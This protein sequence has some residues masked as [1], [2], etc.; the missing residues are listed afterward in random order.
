MPTVNV[1]NR[2]DDTFIAK[3]LREKES[4]SMFQERRHDDWNE[5][6]ELYRNKVF[7]NRL[8]QRQAVNIPL[9]KETVKTL[10]S[11]IDDPPDVEWKELSGD[12]MKE[13]IFQEVWNT[14]YD[15]HN[16][17]GIDVQDKKNVLLFGRS[18]KKLNYANGSVELKVLDVFDV[19]VDPL[20]DPLDIET[21]RFV[22]HRNIFRSVRDILADER[23]DKKGR[24][25]L[26]QWAMSDEGMVMSQRNKEDWEKKMERIRAMGITSDEFPLFAGGDMLVNLTEHYTNVWNKDEKK[27]ERRVAVYAD[28]SIILMDEKLT[29]IIG[30]EFWPFV[31]WG[32]DVETSDF[33]SDG[34]A[35]LVRTPNKVVNIW[36][37]QLVENRTLRNFQMHWFDATVQNF[38][39]Q[40]Y[41]PGPGRMLPAPGKPSDTIMP[42]EIDGLDETFNAIN[43]I[44]GIIE[45]GTSATAIEKGVSERKQITLGEVQTLVGKAMERTVAMAKFY[46]RSWSELAMKWYGIM[47]ANDKE[48][49]EL[50]KTSS[51]GKI[52]AKKV[53]P[54]DWKSE[55]GYKAFVRSTSEQE[56]EKTKAVQRFQFL[57]QV[58]PENAALRRIGQK[59]MLELAD[60]TSEE[61]REIAE[62]E[63]QRMERLEEQENSLVAQADATNQRNVER[64]ADR[65]GGLAEDGDITQRLS[66]LVAANQQPA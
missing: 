11:K 29:E 1:I 51:Q 40:T 57:M 65:T 19:I 61:M 3:L 23:Y 9:M 18:M 43:F 55:A 37:S 24:D 50:H 48:I 36:F 25:E 27:F 4:A 52:W 10:L 35:D 33:W 38:E 20:T 53:T 44:T 6:Y 28:D 66:E 41:E 14:D 64:V 22:I 16:V 49:R 47:D 39:P 31:T 45:R 13:L 63:R 12:Q 32:D 15:E 60:L 30:V 17:E 21:A 46:R 2:T 7:T 56:D 54:S 62:E 59:R 58:F 26:K 42:V 34:P 5:N 8:T